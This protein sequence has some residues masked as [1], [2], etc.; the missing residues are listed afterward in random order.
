MMAD[1]VLTLGNHTLVHPSGR[2]PLPCP[3][4]SLLWFDAPPAPLPSGHG[5]FGFLWY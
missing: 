3:T 4:L 2:M 1:V 5:M